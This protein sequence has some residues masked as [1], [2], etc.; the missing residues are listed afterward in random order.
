MKIKYVL[1]KD[2]T[3][4]IVPVLQRD[5]GLITHSPR[6]EVYSRS[7]GQSASTSGLWN[8]TNQTLSW[9]KCSPPFMHGATPTPP[10]PPPWP[11]FAFMAWCFLMDERNL[12]YLLCIVILS[13]ALRWSRSSHPPCFDRHQLIW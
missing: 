4:W 5:N 6:W 13:T 2:T 11:K 7:A 12:I 9:Y 1:E 8:P 3:Q 10:P